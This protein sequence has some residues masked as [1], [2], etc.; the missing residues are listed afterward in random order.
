MPRIL[1]IDDEKNVADTCA[2]VLSSAGHRVATAK[3]GHAGITLLRS[4]PA[5]LILTDLDMPYGGV[6]A[7]ATLR[8]LHPKIPIIV[9][10][11]AGKSELDTAAILGAHR[12]LAKPFTPQELIAAVAELLPEAPPSP[13]AGT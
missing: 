12:T 5:D 8:K 6:R 7:I 4:E 1:I 3:D 2:Q 11:G 9:M 10:S 13:A